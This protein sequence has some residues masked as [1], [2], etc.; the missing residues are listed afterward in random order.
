[1]MFVKTDECMTSPTHLVEVKV[2]VE[3]FSCHLHVFN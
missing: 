3:L 2:V 1:V